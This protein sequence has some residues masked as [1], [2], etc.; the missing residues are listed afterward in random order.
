MAIWLDVMGLSLTKVHEDLIQIPE[1]DIDLPIVMEVDS[2]PIARMALSRP[3]VT[4]EPAH[5]SVVMYS[6][7]G[8]R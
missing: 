1:A 3:M 5:T 4:V 7:A 6:K 2:V 8:L